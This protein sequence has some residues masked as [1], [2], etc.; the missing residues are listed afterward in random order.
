MIPHSSNPYSS[1]PSKAF[2]KTGVVEKLT[3]INYE[4][5]KKKY[6][7]NDS[8][9]IMTAGSCFAQHIG[10]RLRDKGF[11]VLDYEPS[12]W[13]F[14]VEEKSIFGYGI[15]SARY[16]N[17]YT[18]KQLL[19]LVKEAFGL[20]DPQ[21]IVW[22]NASGKFID[23]L[24]PGI[25]PDGLDSE[26]EVLFHRKYHLSRVKELFCDMSVLIFTLGLTEAWIHKSS[27]TVFPIVPGSIAGEF[28]ADIYE[29]MNFSYDDVRR[30]LIEL[31]EILNNQ[32]FEKKYLFTI[33]PVPLTATASGQHV[34]VATTY[35]KSLLRAVIGELYNTS[36]NIDYFPSYEIVTSPW[37]KGN[38][39]AAN[40]RSVMSEAVDEVMEVFLSQHHNNHIKEPYPANV[41]FKDVSNPH[42][43]VYQNDLVCEEMILELMNKNKN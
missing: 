14:P 37:S 19:Q 26:E 5:Y 8:A 9:K 40:Q 43:E 42:H 12:A 22:K 11:N 13:Y 27:G 15:Y 34:Q 31:M 16:G 21:N 1:Y 2:W 35:S 6:E 32:S 18:V 25:E 24:R 41:I 17:I 30:D 4:L 33:S 38:K 10:N 39:F 36:P 29:F 20:W 23:A 7:I 28:R 3:V